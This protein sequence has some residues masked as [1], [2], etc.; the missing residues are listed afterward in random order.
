MDGK[1]L[2]WKDHLTKK[3]INKLKNYFGLAIR[4]YSG[5]SIF[6]LKK[7]IGAVHFHCSEANDLETWHKTTQKY[8]PPRKSDSWCKNQADTI[9]DTNTYKEK[10]GILVLLKDK[11]KFLIWVMIDCWVNVY[12]AKLKILVEL[13]TASYRNDARK[14]SLQVDRH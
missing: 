7:A 6:Q 9:N 8:K 14:I 5:T 12:M 10:P 3:V 4:K 1:P 11:I 2:G 13:L